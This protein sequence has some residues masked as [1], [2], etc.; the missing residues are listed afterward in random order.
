[1]SELANQGTDTIESSI[2]HTL[3]ANVEN[4][5][6]TGTADING[7]GNALDNVLTGNTGA[8]RLDGGAGATRWRAAPATT[9]MSSTTPATR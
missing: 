4:L 3:G 1:V 8:N 7:T 2:S 5:V 6:L 9:P